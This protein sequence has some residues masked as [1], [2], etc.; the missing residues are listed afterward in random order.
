MVVIGIIGGTG[1]D[2]PNILENPQWKKVHTPYGAPSDRFTIGK[3]SG[4]SV[5]VLPRHGSHHQYSPSNVNYR[6][7]INAMKELGVT[8]LIAPTAC[9]SLREEIKPG[10]LVL[11]DQFI[12]RT[13]KRHQTFYDGHEIMHIPMAEPFCGKL[14]NL[15]FSSAARLGIACH[16]AG[17]TVTIEGP[18]FSTRAESM[19]FRS[20]NADVI[21]MTTVPEAVLAREAGIHY[22]AIAMVTDYDCW[23]QGEEVSLEKVMHTM[24]Q[25]AENVKNVIIHAIS[26][27]SD[28]EDDCTAHWKTSRM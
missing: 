18:R 26:N 11:L 20:W 10:E 7:N 25:N 21:N 19:V 24:K 27:V 22:S 2:D 6:A 16:P 5:V 17:T 14:R 8:H 9:G 28:G 13:T 1:V 12:D 15:L 4:V 23:K 3:V